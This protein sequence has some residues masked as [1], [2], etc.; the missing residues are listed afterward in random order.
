MRFMTIAIHRLQTTRTRLL[1]ARS[2]AYAAGG[3]GD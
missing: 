1:R 2:A 3:P